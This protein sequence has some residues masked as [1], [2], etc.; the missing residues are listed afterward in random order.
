MVGKGAAH[1]QAGDVARIGRIGLSGGALERRR[2]GQAPA[3]S[4]LATAIALSIE[5]AK[6]MFDTLT[7]A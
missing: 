6:P 5:I 2:V 7:P 1:R 4:E 3:I